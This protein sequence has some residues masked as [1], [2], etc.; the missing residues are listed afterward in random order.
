MNTCLCHDLIFTLRDP[1]RAPEAR[2]PFYATYTI[3]VSL[4]VS[5]V[6]VFSWYLY[7][8]GY[9]LFF[10]FLIYIGYAV[11]SVIVAFQFVRKPGISGEARR[12]VVNRHV[13]Y[14]VV[15]VVCQLYSIISKVFV[16]FRK[17]LIDDE[18]ENVTSYF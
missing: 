8:Y 12:M 4:I 9:I 6:R 14:I 18:G 5:L 3:I 2:Y 10:I 15:N 11:A 7:L 17:D 13:S 1:F 16:P